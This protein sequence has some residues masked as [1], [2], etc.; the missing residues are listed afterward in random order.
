MPG[1]FRQPGPVGR[2]E[3]LGIEH[4]RHLREKTI[5]V[6]V[7]RADEVVADHA[8]QWAIDAP[9][10]EHAEGLVLEPVAAGRIVAL[11]RAILHRYLGKRFRFSDLRP[12]CRRLPVLRRR[13]TAARP[14]RRRG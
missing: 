14:L 11:A 8:A 12:P 7:R 10:D 1:E 6:V 4:A 13:T 3:V 2:L 5:L 9:M